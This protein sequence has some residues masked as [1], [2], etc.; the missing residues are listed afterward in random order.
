MKIRIGLAAKERV[1]K[2]ATELFGLRREAELVA[3]RPVVTVVLI[4]HAAL[5]PG[6]I[7]KAVS[8]LRSA[9]AVQIHRWLR[10]I[11]TITGQ[12]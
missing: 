11:W 12:R 3:K 7:P 4:S 6:A 1:G 10:E 9:T 5:G 8:S 2:A